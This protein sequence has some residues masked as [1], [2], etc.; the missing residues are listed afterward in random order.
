[1]KA[2]QVL[3]A[4]VRRVT[5]ICCSVPLKHYCAIISF[6][7]KQEMRTSCKKHVAVECACVVEYLC[8]RFQHFT[9]LNTFSYSIFCTIVALEIACRRN[10]RN[11]N[12]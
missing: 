10:E 8:A 4:E 1:M 9:T 3:E 5:G 12:R 2:Q 7:R 6:V 11:R